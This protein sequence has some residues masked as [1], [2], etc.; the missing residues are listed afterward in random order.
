MTEH[1]QTKSPQISVLYT[2]LT[3][4]GHLETR[5]EILI[6]ARTAMLSV[7][8][9]A[10]IK[11]DEQQSPLPVDVY[12]PTKVSRDIVNKAMS[13][14]AQTGGALAAIWKDRA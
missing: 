3:V 6:A 10:P 5:F 14:V 2:L 11:L 7:A 12:F 4:T 13:V 8:P 1:T 9:A